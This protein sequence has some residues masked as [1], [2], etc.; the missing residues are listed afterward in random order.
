MRAMLSCTSWVLC[1]EIMQL[2]LI[3]RGSSPKNDKFISRSV[4]GAVSNGE[5]PRCMQ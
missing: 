2:I 1:Y 3:K 4:R 5:G